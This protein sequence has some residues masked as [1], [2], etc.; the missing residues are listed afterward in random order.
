[1]T[2]AE[3]FIAV[4]IALTAT[5]EA[6]APPTY[7]ATV[8]E[9]FRAKH[10]LNPL[11]PLARDPYLIPNFNNT[12]SQDAVCAVLYP[13]TN[14]RSTYRLQTFRDAADAAQVGAFVTHRLPCGYCSNLFD[15][16]VYMKTPDIVSPMKTCGLLSMV[17][18]SWALECVA[19]S[20]GFSPDCG[21]L[22]L[23]DVINSRGSCFDV[24]VA[25]LIEN[26]PNNVPANSTNLNPCLACDEKMSAPTFEAVAARTMRNS[27]LLSSINRPAD[28]IY[29]VTHFYY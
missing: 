14:N 1:M 8:I 7:N 11:P 28:Q 2:L 6:W 9:A 29:Q 3:L 23:F 16:S 25:A 19:N 5:T 4:V 22:W 21:K 20:I 10:N 15:L 17:N 27:G 24:C 13:D 18:E 12:V 26:L